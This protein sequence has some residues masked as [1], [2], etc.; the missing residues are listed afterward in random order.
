MIS[1]K[2]E[3]GRQVLSVFTEDNPVDVADYVAKEGREGV[4]KFFTEDTAMTL[5][6][7]FIAFT[8]D[9][10]AIYFCETKVENAEEYLMLI[11][12]LSKNL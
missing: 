5:K 12:I 2:L 3:D 10:S 7:D 8:D 9:G 4:I 11:R 6:M 1:S